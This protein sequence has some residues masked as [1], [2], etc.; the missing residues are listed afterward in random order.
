M[1][2]VFTAVV[3]WPKQVNAHPDKIHHGPMEVILERHY[4][5]GDISEEIIIENLTESEVQ[6]KYSDW[7][8]VNVDYNRMVL[9]KM[10]MIFLLY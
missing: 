9:K 4:L 10:W 3:D 8:L 2:G 1:I 5:D 7:I 6:K